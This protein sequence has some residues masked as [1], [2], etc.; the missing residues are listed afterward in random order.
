M[1]NRQ[2][3]ISGQFFKIHI[4]EL[5]V[6]LV[7]YWS[8]IFAFFHLSCPISVLKIWQIC[9]GQREKDGNNKS[10]KDLNVIGF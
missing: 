6:C 8:Q 10:K 5:E 1:I 7:V 4:Q 9:C 2:N 3:D